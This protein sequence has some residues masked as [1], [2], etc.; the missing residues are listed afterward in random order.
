MVFYLVRLA[1]KIRLGVAHALPER[2]LVEEREVALEVEVVVERG[3]RRVA[4]ARLV[5]APR[6]VVRR[7]AALRRGARRPVAAGEASLPWKRK[8]ENV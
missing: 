3:R 5:A 8:K 4:E 6:L 2:A 1:H 7:A